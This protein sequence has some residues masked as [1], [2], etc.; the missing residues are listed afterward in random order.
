MLPWVKPMI[1]LLRWVCWHADGLGLAAER[2]FNRQ[3]LSLVW[4][5]ALCMQGGAL[6]GF[7]LHD[8][9]AASSV[10]VPSNGTS[11]QGQLQG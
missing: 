4:C 3:S 8:S 6:A 9:R 7:A 10:V 5:S 11:T 1:G 2:T